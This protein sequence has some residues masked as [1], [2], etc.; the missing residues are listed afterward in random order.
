MVAILDP[1]RVSCIDLHTLPSLVSIALTSWDDDEWEHE[2]QSYTA[3][4]EPATGCPDC[5]GTGWVRDQ[6]DN[7]APCACN[8]EASS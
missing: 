6:E 8:P 7:A 4:A 5:H 1:E 2:R 3:D